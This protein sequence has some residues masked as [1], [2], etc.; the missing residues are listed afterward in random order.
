MG[1]WLKNSE[2]KRTKRP[3]IAARRRAKKGRSS[4]AR[5]WDRPLFEHLD[6]GQSTSRSYLAFL[7]AIPNDFAGVES[8]EMNKDRLVLR[9]RT[10]T[11]PRELT[12]DVEGLMPD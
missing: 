6:A 12:V 7:L 1:T 3:P 5:I 8:I 10:N 2:T 9:E 4:K 11:A